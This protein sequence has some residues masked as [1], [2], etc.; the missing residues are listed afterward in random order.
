[1]KNDNEQDDAEEIP[2]KLPENKATNNKRAA[3]SQKKLKQFLQKNPIVFIFISLV[4]FIMIFLADNNSSMMEL[5]D[6]LKGLQLKIHNI[7]NNIAKKKLGLLLFASTHS[8][9]MEDLYQFCL[10]Y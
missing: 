1:M 4:I 2:M 10:N 8:E 3:S 7:D 5:N 9:V 6:H